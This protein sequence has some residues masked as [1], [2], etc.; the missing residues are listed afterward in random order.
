VAV[1]ELAGLDLQARVHRMGDGSSGRDVALHEV[2]QILSETRDYLCGKEP[3]VKKTFPS[4]SHS[5]SG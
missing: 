3:T 5:K 4:A 2:Y 1:G